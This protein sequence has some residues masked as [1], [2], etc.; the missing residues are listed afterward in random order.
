MV[1]SP[2]TKGKHPKRLVVRL[3]SPRTSR[4]HEVWGQTYDRAIARIF[5]AAMIRP[6]AVIDKCTPW[7]HRVYVV[8]RDS[9]HFERALVLWPARI[10]GTYQFQGSHDDLLQALLDDINEVSL[11]LA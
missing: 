7:V 2:R 1:V 3:A 10:I 8:A 6:I 11:G 5:G 9:I 4:R